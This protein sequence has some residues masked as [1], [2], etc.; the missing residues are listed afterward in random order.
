MHLIHP[1]CRASELG[2]A[3][4]PLNVL[5]TQ[6]PEP[7]AARPLQRL[8][9]YPRGH[10]VIKGRTEGLS[11]LMSRHCGIRDWIREKIRAEFLFFWS[12]ELLRPTVLALSMFLTVVDLLL[13]TTY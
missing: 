10:T 1:V 5:R 2:L 7:P 6:Y 9:A 11:P 4:P 13:F 3:W 12:R 8:I